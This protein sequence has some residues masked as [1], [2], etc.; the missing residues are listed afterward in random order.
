MQEESICIPL[1]EV[2]LISTEN[3]DIKTSSMMP[4]SKENNRDLNSV[5]KTTSVSPIL[6]TVHDIET[7]TTIPLSKEHTDGFHVFRPTPVSKISPD[8][9]D[10]IVTKTQT[11]KAYFKGM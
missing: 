8:F 10:E 2:K 5:A 9:H 11:E 4:K 1:L 7:S 3:H 6:T